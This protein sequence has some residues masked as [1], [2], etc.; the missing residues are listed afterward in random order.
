MAFPG[1][2]TGPIWL[3][4]QAAVASKTASGGPLLAANNLSDLTNVVLARLNLGLGTAATA[5]ASAFDPAGAAAT[6]LASAEAYANSLISGGGAFLS[7]ANNLSDVSSVPTSLVNLGLGPTS[8]VAFGSLTAGISGI[9]DNG[10]FTIVPTSGAPVA[11]TYNIPMDLNGAQ[12]CTLSSATTFSVSG[13]T[14][15]RLVVLDIINTSGSAQTLTFTPGGGVSFVF[16]DSP[17]PATIA[18]STRIQLRL[19]AETTTSVSV[20]YV[21]ATA[22][23]VS[24]V[25]ATGAGI[26][27][28]PTT[29]AVLIANTGVTSIVAG[30]NISISAATGAVTIDASGGS[31]F[32]ASAQLI[33]NVA[34]TPV[35]TNGVFNVQAYGATGN[36]S[37]PDTTAVNAAIAAFNAYSA[38]STRGTLYFPAGVYNVGLLTVLTLAGGFSAS[39]KGDGEGASVILQTGSNNGLKVS[40]G[41][42]TSSV[43]VGFLGF[44]ASGSGN[45]GLFIDYGSS[46][47]DEA[48]NACSLHDLNFNSAGGTWTYGIFANGGWKYRIR[49][50]NGMMN[51][52][53]TVPTLNTTTGAS[54]VICIVGGTNILISDIY[55]FNAGAGLMLLP[56]T[57]ANPQSQQGVMVNN[58]IAVNVN[59]GAYIAPGSTSLTSGNAPGSFHFMN[60]L[61]DQ[62]NAAPP[63]GSCGIFAD[64][65][66]GGS[67]GVQFSNR[68]QVVVTSCFA[69]QNTAS[70]TCTFISLKNASQSTINGCV[71]FT[72]TN[73]MNL[74]NTSVT[75]YLGALVTNNHTGGAALVTSG[76]ATFTSANNVS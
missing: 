41:S 1:G 20:S 7:K 21:G 52:T 2:K 62:G 35:K 55:A 70:G 50:I 54:S 65:T 25:T 47:S 19:F 38:T 53:G 69:T 39:I 33:T 27:A 46:A 44:Q 31:T 42:L 5:N 23:G 14:G 73:F 18:G 10:A 34:A 30:T 28:S 57:G 74:A 36:G 11:G 3:E 51:N 8:N 49:S 9:L 76:G 58:L 61:F 59:F 13:V 43:D 32:P 48:V 45:A 72:G 16:V 17:A 4:P 15:G 12:I 22:S 24:S 29:G 71:Y 66:A 67:G 26:T 75:G 6:A 68:G 63:A 64:C 40:M 56:S 37:T 60:C